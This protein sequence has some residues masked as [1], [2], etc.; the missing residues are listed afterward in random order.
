MNLIFDL[1]LGN[2]PVKLI[3]HF[4]KGQGLFLVIS[5]YI[6]CHGID[7]N[8]WHLSHFLVKLLASFLI[9][10]NNTFASNLFVPRNIHGVIFAYTLMYLFH[11]I[12]RFIFVYVSK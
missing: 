12:H 11:Y 9:L 3:P 6:D 4:A 2:D 5:S 1:L 8:F 10:A 7:A